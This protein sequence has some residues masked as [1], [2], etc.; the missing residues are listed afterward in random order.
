MKVCLDFWG[1]RPPGEI[2]N[3]CVP[4]ELTLVA[5]GQLVAELILLAI[6]GIVSY[7]FFKYTKTL[8]KKRT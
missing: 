2:P 7:R 3:Y 8:K 4:Y 6:M 5:A 1:R